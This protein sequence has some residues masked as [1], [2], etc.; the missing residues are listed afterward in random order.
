MTN[1]LYL[2]WLEWPEDCFRATPGDIR[3]LKTLVP[4]GARVCVA[5]SESSF[6]RML[7]CATHVLVWNFKP[8][9]FARAPRLKVL[10][11]PAAGREL[12]PT[13]GPP[14]VTIHFGG[15]HGKIISET[16]MAFVLAW[17]HGFFARFP[18][19]RIPN[20]PRV[21]MS[22]VCGR[23]AGT[24]AV[25]VGYGRIGRAIGSRL[26]SLG[27]AVAGFGRR[28]IRELP[29]AAATADWF[30]M[31]L[32]GDTGTTDFLDAKLI[33]RLP[34]RCVVVNIGRGNA[35]DEPALFA[36]LSAGR[37]AGAYL[38]VRKVE[39]NFGNQGGARAVLAAGSVPNLILMPHSSAF[40]RDYIHDF[41]EELKDEG[42][43]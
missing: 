34:R 9:W 10:A 20:W 30:I 22:A 25:I 8:E 35:V 5:H 18:R 6:R 19:S 12:V 23:V 39:P 2:V 4:S 17:S 11:T 42:L 26:S 3:H 32:P 15:F 14:G 27:I 37:L 38:D 7:P 1:N 28:N 36:A 43:I 29:R 24:K 31:A 40:Y 16:V 21:E 41:F 13:A 33:A